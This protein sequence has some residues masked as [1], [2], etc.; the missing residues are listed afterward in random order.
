MQRMKYRVLNCIFGDCNKTL[1]NVNERDN[2]CEPYLF[3]RDY[4]AKRGV[5]FTA[6]NA[7]K[8]DGVSWVVFWDAS[9]IPPADPIR[10]GVFWIKNRLLGG[11]LRDLFRRRIPGVKRALILHEPFCVCPRNWDTSLHRK[12][13]LIFTWDPSLC[14]SV[15]YV[16]FC[17]PHGTLRP[18]DRIPSFESRK[19]ICDISRNN[20]PRFA[21]NSAKKRF[22]LI[23]FF[24]QNAPNEFDLYGSGW[25]PSVGRYLFRYLRDRKIFYSKVA[26]WRGPVRSKAETLGK[27]KFALCV[28]NSTDREGYISNKIFD[29]MQSGCV[30][31][32]LGP[33][34]RYAHFPRGT[35]VD[36]ADF[37]SHGMLLK[38][39]Q[40]MD[41]MTHAKMIE[42]IQRYL[43]SSE[44]KK[45]SKE[46][47]ARSIYEAL[48]SKAGIP[49]AAPLLE[50]NSS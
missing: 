49:E 23:Q 2:C 21:P 44:H 34:D 18:S 47:F 17:L 29:A 8:L 24:S 19:L 26:T 4:F 14:T 20:V 11:D 33:P 25:N 41:S 31:V 27:Y 1:F 16:R 6:S 39:L 42:N 10:R 5:G 40:G 12:F 35:F 46:G 43:N 9:S 15:E 7:K 36:V 38:Y 13:D 3:C 45:F 48:M 50:E 37:E 32:Y 30:P 28:E 22:E